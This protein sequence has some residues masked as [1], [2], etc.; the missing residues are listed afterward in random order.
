MT[1][2]AQ[3]SLAEQIAHH[4]ERQIV[5]GDLVEGE[6]IQEMRIVAELEVS[7]GSVREALLILQRRHLIDIFPRR[8]AVVTELTPALV[9]SLYDVLNLH[10]SWVVRRWAEAWQQASLEPFMDGIQQIQA[11]VVEE[12]TELFFERS[13]EWLKSASVFAANPYLDQQLKD[14]QPSVRRAYYLALQMNKRELEESFSF[15]RGLLDAVLLRQS[16]R[17]TEYLEEF[18]MHQRN[19]VLESLIR[20]KQ[21]EMAWARRHRR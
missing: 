5:T 3:D 12:D 9:K 14:M 8:G 2:R 6:R 1:F 10:L 21:I 20:V 16:E 19:L 17:A 13:L 7:R 11:A 4:L 18:V 15:L